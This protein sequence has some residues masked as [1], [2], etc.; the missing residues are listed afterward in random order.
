MAVATIPVEELMA[1]PSA[2]EYLVIISGAPG[3]KPKFVVARDVERL[4]DIG[5]KHTVL[6]VF[7]ESPDDLAIAKTLGESRLNEMRKIKQQTEGKLSPEELD[8]IR[9]W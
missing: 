3:I 9:N 4:A 7:R 6:K 1:R 2:P 5:A 8:A